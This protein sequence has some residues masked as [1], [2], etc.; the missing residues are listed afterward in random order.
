MSR[1]AAVGPHRVPSARGTSR[2]AHSALA[3]I[4]KLARREHR[5]RD[6]IPPGAERARRRPARDAAART[7]RPPPRPRTGRQRIRCNWSAPMLRR[8][9]PARCSTAP[10]PR[11]T[12]A[13]VRYVGWMRA[14]PPKNS[15]SRR[16]RVVDPRPG[17]GHGADAGGDAHDRDD[18]HDVASPGAKQPIGDHVEHAAAH[19]GQLTDRQHV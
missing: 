11:S 17:K 12:L 9:A 8:R 4:A 3:T 18:S 6:R 10:A 14:A 5:R 19:L 15:P 16:H 1:P 2:S 13:G 7:A